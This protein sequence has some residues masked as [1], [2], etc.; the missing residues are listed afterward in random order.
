GAGL[1]SG[2]GAAGAGAAGAAASAVRAGAAGGAG[3]A[4][5]GS[6]STR[7]RGTTQAASST[8]TRTT[9]VLGTVFMADSSSWWVTRLRSSLLPR[10]RV[11]AELVTTGPRSAV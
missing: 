11:D 7:D 10:S 9:R 4:G 8:A 3:G 1:A 2:L 5:G 6:A